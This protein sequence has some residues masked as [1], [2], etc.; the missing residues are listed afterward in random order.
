MVHAGFC[1]VNAFVLRPDKPGI[2]TAKSAAD[3]AV[4]CLSLPILVTGQLHPNTFV[5][6]RLWTAVG[7][8]YPMYFAFPK[9]DYA[10]IRVPAQQNWIGDGWVATARK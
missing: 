9:W 3:Y 2:S 6:K 1:V 10:F 4:Q 7:W 5:V 8:C